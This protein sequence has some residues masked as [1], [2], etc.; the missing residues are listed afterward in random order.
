MLITLKQATVD[1]VQWDGD[2]SDVITAHLGRPD[3]R[4]V[5]G[6]TTQPGWWLHLGADGEVC[7]ASDRAMRARQ[8]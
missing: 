4:V 8:A 1:A 5:A 3:W 7:Q 6:V 2:N